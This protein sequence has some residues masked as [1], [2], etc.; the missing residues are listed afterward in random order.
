MI[1][2][3]LGAAVVVVLLA[4]AVGFFSAPAVHAGPLQ[5]ESTD[6]R[7]T[8][9]P[10]R[11]FP[12]TVNTSVPSGGR[13]WV[14]SPSLPTRARAIEVT[15]QAAGGVDTFASMYT[16]LAG[17]TNKN[18]L[19]FCSAIGLAYTWN[20][21]VKPVGFIGAADPMQACFG[22]V[23]LLT[24]GGRALAAEVAR[25]RCPQTLATLRVA[26][27]SEGYV[28][29]GS[30]RKARKPALRVRCTESEAGMSLRISTRSKKSSLRS[31]V[32]ERLTIGF[33]S[34]P[35]AQG[36]STLTLTYGT[37]R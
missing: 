6:D 9:S 29:K 26:S 19:L 27:T 33:M 35:G 8:V 12:I 18:R 24:G 30:V 7:G 36:D 23:A 31:I 15:I 16:T 4:A 20:A 17:M 10:V 22:V 1:G 3:R 37:P 11:G 32:G 13:A 2:G 34:K 5:Q 14:G 21:D 28:P 25:S